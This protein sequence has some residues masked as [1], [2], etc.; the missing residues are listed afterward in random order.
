[1]LIN[2]TARRYARALFD[3][4][5][6]TGCGRE[7]LDDVRSVARLIRS[8]PELGGFL[9]QY[10]MGREARQKALASLFSGRVNQLTWR[11]I[12]FVEIKKRLGLLADM[13][14]AY[15]E[16]SDRASGILKAG[17]VSAFGRDA[18]S[19]QAIKSVLAAKYRAQIEL[20]VGEDRELIGG[21]VVRAGD[22]V[23]DLSVAGVLAAARKKLANA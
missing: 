1:M 8:S 13:C 9:G 2:K 17:V 19:E 22:M 6:E 10:V 20:D 16:I 21:F 23:Y 12:R 3:L 4:A 7:I 15:V 5:V 11:F 18:R 14:A